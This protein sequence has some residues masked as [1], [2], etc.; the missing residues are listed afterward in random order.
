MVW[1]NGPTPLYA[2]GREDKRDFGGEPGP[3]GA[4]LTPMYVRV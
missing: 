2:V 3:K 1:A 4:R